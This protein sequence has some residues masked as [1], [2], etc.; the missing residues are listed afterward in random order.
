MLGT[1]LSTRDILVNKID[2]PCLPQGNQT[3]N[4]IN[5]SIVVR[6]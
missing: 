6:K 5:Q 3:I 2:N 1:I 4:K